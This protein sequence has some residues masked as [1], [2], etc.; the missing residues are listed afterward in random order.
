MQNLLGREAKRLAWQTGFS[1]RESELNGSAFMQALVFSCLGTDQVTYSHL[2]ASALQ[3]GANVSPQAIEQRFS[4]ASAALA[5][6]VLAVSLQAVISPEPAVQ[7]LLARFNGVYVRDSSVVRLP[8]E[9]GPLWPGVGNQGGP[10]AGVKLQVRLELGQGQL[11][12]PLVQAARAADSRSPFQSEALPAGAVRL[13]DLG[14]FSLNQFAQDQRQGVYTCSRYKV[15]TQVYD[16]TGQVFD[17]LAWLRSQTEQRQFER[18]IRLG[19][20]AQFA[21]RLLAIRVPPE[22]EAQRRR[23]L[24]TYARKKQVS[25]TQTSLAL[26]RWTLLVTDVPLERLSIDEAQVLLAARW[27]IE[28][29]FKLWK[30]VLQIDTWRSQDPWRILTEFYAKLI[31]VVIL[32]WTF[33]M[34]LWQNPHRS[35]WKATHIVRRFASHLALALPDLAQLVVVLQLIRVHF[36]R[37][38][39]LNMRRKKPGT[40]QRLMAVP[41]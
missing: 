34:G 32:H 27:Q 29:L 7:G 39:R 38:C 6:A 25:P 41:A 8:A 10:T 14:Y 30:S 1:Q 11:A 3:A 33:L 12:G 36:D 37:N 2:S 4:P 40:S 13:G 17:L 23:K 24:R 20:Q 18:T 35:L 21:C 19:Q 28:I 15:G 26:T 5:E 9:L 31:A 16:A 22:V